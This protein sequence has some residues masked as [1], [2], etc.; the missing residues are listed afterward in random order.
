MSPVVKILIGW[1]ATLAAAWLYHGPLGNGA[2]FIERLEAQARALIA[3]TEI[4]GVQVS[5]GRKPLTRLAVLSGGADEFQREGQGELKGLNDLVREID[6]VS[7]VRWV[8]ETQDE[9]LTLPLL[10]ELMI[11]SSLAYLIGLVVARLIWGRKKREGF[12]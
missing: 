8:D 5:F 7:G 1:A 4:P 9:G 2:A 6:G 11:L 10:L 12:Y 3:D